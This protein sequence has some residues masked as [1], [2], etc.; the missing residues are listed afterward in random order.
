VELLNSLLPAFNTLS[1]VLFVV[2][3]AAAGLRMANRFWRIK[4]ARLGLPI[5]LKRDI[6]LFGAL[7]LYFGSVLVVLAL[8]IQGLAQ[9][10]WW[11]MPRGIMVLAAMLYWVKVEY[12]LED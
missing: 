3:A 2:L 1:L 12:H 6:V 11:V 5:L 8:G 4:R 10:W 9:Q 7:A